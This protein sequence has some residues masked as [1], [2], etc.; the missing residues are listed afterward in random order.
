VGHLVLFGWATQ[1]MEGDEP[2]FIVLAAAA[3][4]TIAA[5]VGVFIVTRAGKRPRARSRHR[6]D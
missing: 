1:D 6:S 4:L 2:V 5:V 3:V